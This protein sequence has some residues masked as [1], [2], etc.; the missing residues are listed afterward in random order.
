MRL[1]ST[2]P[3]V[4]SVPNPP[5]PL[6]RF[7]AWLRSDMRVLRWVFLALYALLIVGFLLIPVLEDDVDAAGYVI[8]VGVVLAAQAILIFGSGTV[9]L[10]RPIRRRRLILPVT[11]AAIMLAVLVAGAFIAMWELLYLDS[12]FEDDW[13]T[14]VFFGTVGVTW[15]GWTVILLSRLRTAPR[16]T[17]LRKL[18]TWIFAGSLAELLATVP[19]H[20][21][22]SRRPGCLVGIGTAIGITA[23]LAVMLFSFGPA[24][25]ILFLRPRWRAEMEAG[26]PYC[27]ACGYDL[28]MSKERC[29]ECG[30]PIT[31]TA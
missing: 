28:R 7:R 21:I 5:T 11:I 22:V 10:C 12:K 17:V 27:P 24:I 18:N 20:V 4:V 19:S 25:V 8:V 9:S 29:P 6:S 1:P 23:G 30:L 26:V 16:Y 13:L 2:E 14:T 31:P 3:V 15:V